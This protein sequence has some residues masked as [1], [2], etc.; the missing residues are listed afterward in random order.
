MKR[1]YSNNQI[2]KAGKILVS[3]ESYSDDEKV[4]ANEVLTYWRTIHA[5]PINTF[6]STLRGKLEKLGYK[7]AII[8]QRLKRS[9]SIISKLERFPNMKLSTMQ[10]IAGIRA[11]VKNI[12]EVRNLEGNYLQTRFAHKRIDSADYITKPAKSGYR[13]IHLVYEYCKTN[14]ESNKLKIELQLRTKLQHNWATAVETMGTFLGQSLKSSQGDS[15]WL[16]YFKLVSAG[17]SHLENSPVIEEYKNWD[18]K[19]VFTEIIEQ[20]KKLDIGKKLRGFTVAADHINDNYSNSKYNLITLNTDKRTVHV[21]SYSGKQ[22]KKAN[23]DYTNIE[24]EINKGKN[25]QAVLVSTSSIEN[26]RKAYPNYFLDTRDFLD[27]LNLIYNRN[28]KE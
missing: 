22:L 23:V 12:N 15:N 3:P 24:K 14:H 10:D 8:A 21:R 4:F 9:F 7:Q 25:V 13:G 20:G 27:K 19:K 6:Q 11:I 1:K 17:F 5:T 28:I 26:L 16:E 2:K 18:R